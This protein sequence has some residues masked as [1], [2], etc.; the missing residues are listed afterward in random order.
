MASLKKFLKENGFVSVKLKRT[1]TNHLEIRAT[2]NGVKGCFIV[3][4]GA[5]NTCVSLDRADKFGLVS[6]VS[7]VKAAGAGAVDLEA[8]VSGH[9]SL[10]LGP[11]KKSRLQ[12]VLFDMSHVNHALTSQEAEAVDGIIG[13]DILQKAKAV[14]DYRK[15]RIYL[16]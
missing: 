1:S 6:E 10:Q 12:V 8:R 5:S 14:I 15:Y 13:A 11:W 3:D 2:L 7:E 9:N 16:K 4:T